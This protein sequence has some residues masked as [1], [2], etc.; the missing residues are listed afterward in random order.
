V[1]LL[2]WLQA[3]KSK[4]GVAAGDRVNR[5]VTNSQRAR[6]D[7]PPQRIARLIDSEGDVS[8]HDLDIQRTGE[9][10]GEVK[11]SLHTRGSAVTKQKVL[12]FKGIEDDY[13]IYEEEN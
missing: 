12:Q 9:P 7:L 10:Y 8:V 3:R 13:L 6:L 2:D 4:P 5:A 1:R 11:I